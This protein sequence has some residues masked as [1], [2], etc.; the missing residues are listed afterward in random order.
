MTGK[1]G[2][3]DQRE[4]SYA[5]L[6]HEVV[7]S[8]GRPLTFQEISDQVNRCRPV[9]TRNPKA[10]IRSALGQVKQAISL[11][12]GHYGYL[13]DLLQGS[14]PRLLLTEKKPANY[15]LIY[16][17]EIRH[18]LWPSFLEIQK[19]TIRRPVQVRLPDGDEVDFPLEFFGRGTWGSPM[20]EGLRRYF[21][22]K[23][24]AA[25]DSLLIRVVDGQAGGCEAWFESRL[26]QDRAAVAK[27][28]RELADAANRLL[29]GSRS[30]E[31]TIWDLV[32]A[33]LARGVYRSDVAPGP[34]EA[35][36]SADPRF[37]YA[38]L[39][40]WILAEAAT[41]EVQATIRERQRLEHE[42]SPPE[43][44]TPAGREHAGSALAARY[45]MERTM[46]DVGAILSEREFASID[47]ANAFLQEM[48]AKGGVPRRSAQ[49]PLEPARDLTD[50]AWEATSSRER[51]R[52][53]RKALEISPDCADAYVPLAEETARSLREAADL[54]AEGVAAGERA[55]G[56]ES[57][58]EEVGHFWSVIETRPYMRAS[59][60][61]PSFLGHG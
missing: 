21:I 34:L 24:A 3:A 29:Q 56:K 32:V 11:G 59:R 43:A 51:A 48:L 45:A 60:V 7:R 46:A 19:R 23:R 10:T 17:D 38:G 39:Q 49:S 31:A 54:Y 9:T 4:P 47:E 53:A 27:R 6:V 33:L 20:P 22:G 58:A 35:V 42:L 15:P 40:M 61:G 50:A 18:A 8:A 26:K 5:Y 30:R 14:L 28:N 36:L 41:A 57:F 25:G 52:L 2:M 13:P 1:V 37:A 55:L 16:S 44:Q 12:D